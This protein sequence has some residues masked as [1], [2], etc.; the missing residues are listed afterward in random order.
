MSRKPVL[1]TAI[2]TRPEVIKMAPVISVL[3]KSASFCRHTL[4]VTGQHQDLL[5]QAL[6]WFQLKPQRDLK[7]MKPNQDLTN[8]L[9]RLLPV[10][11]KYLDVLRPDAVLVQGDTLTAFGCAFAAYQRRIPVGH[12]EAG[13]R[14]HDFYEPFPEEAQRRLIDQISTW[15]FAP[16]AQAV[17][18]LKAEGISGRRILKTGNTVV[19]ALHVLLEEQA[20][21]GSTVRMPWFTDSQRAR[22]VLTLTMHRR[23]S[24]GS[25]MRQIVRAVEKLLVQVPNAL[26]YFPRHPNPQVIAATRALERHPQ[27]RLLKPLAYPDFI[28]LLSASALVLSDSGGVQEEAPSLGV[29][30]VVLRERTERTELLRTGMAM[31]AGT[32]PQKIVRG[33]LALMR[34]RRAGGDKEKGRRVNPFGDGHAAERIYERLKRDLS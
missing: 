13:L 14:S 27:V 22:P 6:G 28:S 20:Q 19:D 3:S 15:C 16:T 26:L 21:Q 4:C 29:P 18:N 32:D 8:L 11:T 25:G 17:A 33:A 24:F 7:L 5:R 34:R 23:E 31:L 30:V 1:L 12:V 2:G 9:A 10:F